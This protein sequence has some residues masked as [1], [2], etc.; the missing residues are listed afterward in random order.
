MAGVFVRRPFVLPWT[1]LQIL[2]RHLAHEANNDFRSGNQRCDQGLR[3]INK[4]FSVVPLRLSC[5][6][7]AIYRAAR[8][9]VNPSIAQG[10]SCANI[11]THFVDGQHFPFIFIFERPHPVALHLQRRFFNVGGTFFR[12]R[13]HTAAVFCTAALSLVAQGEGLR[14]GCQGDHC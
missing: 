12:S 8:P 6:G 7:K 5:G 10:S 9:H 2:Q 1:T 14:T 4:P 13:W 3:I 11:V